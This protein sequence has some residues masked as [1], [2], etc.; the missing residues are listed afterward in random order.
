MSHES[1][2]ID[3]HMKLVQLKPEQADRLFELTDQN[4]EYLGEFLPWPP[5]VKSV[6]DSRKHI[7]ETIQK[8]RDNLAYTY[9]IEVDG[10][11]AGDI[12]IRNLTEVEKKPEIGYWMSPDYAGKGLMTKAVRALTDYGL[13][14]LA[15]E[16]I[17]IRADPM[18]IGSNKVAEKAGYNQVGVD[19]SNDKI[20]NV[21]SISKSA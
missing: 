17:I 9:S 20:L 10:V 19:T 6:D 14:S 7:E 21:W 8:R 13:Q 2:P 12:S 16:K 1:I 11:I 18:N 5:Y 3:E 4:R 15:L